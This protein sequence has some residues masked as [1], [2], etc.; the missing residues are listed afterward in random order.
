MS[1]PFKLMDSLARR[2]FTGNSEWRIQPSPTSMNSAKRFSLKA[3]GQNPAFS[4]VEV[5]LAIGIVAFCVLSLLTLF[6]VGLRNSKESEDEI[7]AAN[8]TSSLICRMRAAPGVDLTSQ[9]FP[10]GVLTNA[11]GSLF[12][13]PTNAPMWLNGDG[14]RAATAAE[15][16]AARGYAVAAHASYDITN[17]V[18]GVALTL[19]WPAVAVYSNASGQYAITTYID[20]EVP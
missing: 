1:Q 9:G 20:T 8:L 18:A 13:A 11:G 10:F 5:V 14:T 2:E 12:D 17:R 3:A 4:L 15:A 19:W 7:R 6:S 16:L